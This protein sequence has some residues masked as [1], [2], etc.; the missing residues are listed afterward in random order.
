MGTLSKGD[1]EN[2]LNRYENVIAFDEMDD[3]NTEDWGLNDPPYLMMARVAEM[4]ISGELKQGKKKFFEAVFFVN[5][6]TKFNLYVGRDPQRAGD[7]YNQAAESA[8]ASMKGKLSN[9][10]Y[11]L[12]EEAWGEIEE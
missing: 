6:L 4:W 10:Y 3:E 12:A 2:T 7:M 11:M 8:M 9:K 1:A 5:F